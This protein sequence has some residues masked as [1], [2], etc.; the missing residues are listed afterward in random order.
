MTRFMSSS[1]RERNWHPMT[2]HTK[3]GDDGV[4][5]TVRTEPVFYGTSLVPPQSVPQ[6]PRYG[7]DVY[8]AHA[9]HVHARYSSVRYETPAYKA[10]VH[11]D[12]NKLLAIVKRS[13]T[14]VQN[15]EL[16]RAFEQ[17]LVKWLREYNYSPDII[18][19]HEV[20]HYGEHACVRYRIPSLYFT[21]NGGDVVFELYVWN[22]FGSRAIRVGW[23]ALCLLCTNGLVGVRDVD[24]IVRKHTAGLDVRSLIEHAP[25]FISAFKL[26]ADR[27]IAWQKLHLTSG[28]MEDLLRKFPNTS[29]KWVLAMQQR[30]SE[31]ER[32]MYGD[33]LWGLVNAVTWWA[34]H[35]DDTYMRVRGAEQN[36]NVAHALHERAM[37]V[38]QWMETP[39]FLAVTNETTPGQH[40]THIPAHA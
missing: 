14:V 26:F 12:T 33:T 10:L 20:S 6:E 2:N 13:Y 39:Y 1:R 8:E 37:R 18:K 11:N 30:H 7:A 25:F 5:Y 23:R 40:N 28:T 15:T 36:D 38:R 9:Q 24:V 16:F 34:S 17:E 35:D 21:T 4:M 3:H 32:S 27:A 19:F 22:S 29:D 31:N